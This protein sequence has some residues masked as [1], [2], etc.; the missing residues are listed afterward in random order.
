MSQDREEMIAN[1]SVSSS[2]S[3]INSLGWILSGP[4]DVCVSSEL[5]AISPWIM[6]VSFCSLSSSSE[7]CPED[8]YYYYRWTQKQ[9]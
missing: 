7:L 2:T 8:N 6:V 5:L 9:H 4:V 1:G 3:S